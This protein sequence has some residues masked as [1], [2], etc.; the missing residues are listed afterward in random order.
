VDAAGRLI[1][2]SPSDF[3]GNLARIDPQS[4]A[5]EILPVLGL[6]QFIAPYG[7]EVY[8]VP[9]PATVPL[10]FVGTALFLFCRQIRGTKRP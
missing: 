3:P 7:I 10:A 2:F 9:E 8:S 1:A 6:N 5:V 4:G